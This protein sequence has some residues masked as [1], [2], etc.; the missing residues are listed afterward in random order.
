MHVKN[1]AYLLIVLL[2]A[3][4]CNTLPPHPEEP[5]T[6][7]ITNP[8]ADSTPSLHA[9]REVADFSTSQHAAD[10]DPQDSGAQP[11]IA[12]VWQRIRSGL[13]MDRHLQHRSVQER[14]AWYARNQEYL[15]RVATRATPYLY[16]IAGEIEK[17]NMPLELALLPVVESAFHP[18]A[19]SPSDASG[20]WQFIPGTGRTYGLKQNWWY[21]GRRDVV[22]ATGAA[23]DYLEKLHKEFNGDWLLALAA[24]NTGERNVARAIQRNK[25]AGKAQDFWSLRLPRETRGYVPA[26][27]AVA[28]LVANPAGHNVTWKMIPNQPYFAVVDAGSQLDLATM[29]DL[30]GLSMDE[31]YTLNPGFN[32]WATDPAGPHSLLVPVGIAE[33]FASDLEQLPAEDRVSWQRHVI[34]RGETLGLIAQRYRTNVETIRRANGLPGNLI[35]T[36]ESLIIPSSKLPLREY[37]LSLDSRRFQ[38]LSR[39]ESGEK[40]IYTVKR[41]DTLWDIGRQYGISISQ[42]TQWNGISSRS[43]LRPGQKLSLWLT[44]EGKGAGESTVSASP[45]NQPVQGQ[46]NKYVVQQGDSLWLIANRTGTSV[47]ELKQ[48]NNIGER[49]FLQPGQSL[50]LAS[51]NKSESITSTGTDSPAAAADSSDSPIS[52]TV[53]NGD[54]LWLIANRYGISV[55]DLMRWNQVENSDFLRPGQVINVHLAGNTDTNTATM[56]TYVVKKGDSLWLI[57]KRFGT[58]VAKLKSWNN[59]SSGSFLRPGQELVLYITKA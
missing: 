36:G 43:L 22:A 42:L 51:A 49:E 39:S 57:S 15:D 31:I 18:F 3:A 32:R 19:Y 35:H 53:R 34:K 46:D 33:K 14:L 6:V 27:L 30:T 37:T 29:S 25:R 11:A 2:C 56:I 47:N 58:T 20:L 38:G 5:D 4:G 21:D 26:L 8:V 59:L 55:A 1:P 40:Y 10:D 50:T 9:S 17:R 54:S 12:D 13:S 7:L 23:L 24:Y 16:Y 41:G 45:A 44:D 28:E 52:Y 48:L